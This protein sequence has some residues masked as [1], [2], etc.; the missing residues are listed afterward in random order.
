VGQKLQKKKFAGA[1]QAEFCTAFQQ[2][3]DRY[4]KKLKNPKKP[5]ACPGN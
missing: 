4:A 5:S 1:G 3:L 2:I